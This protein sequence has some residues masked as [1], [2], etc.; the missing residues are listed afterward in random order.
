MWVLKVVED[1]KGKHEIEFSGSR[2]LVGVE[3]EHEG[4]PTA[5]VHVLHVLWAR[6]GGGDLEAQMLEVVA[7][8]AET[9]ADFENPHPLPPSQVDVREKV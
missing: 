1:S 5:L 2:E 6:V 3:V 4:P 9:G 7:Q 8:M